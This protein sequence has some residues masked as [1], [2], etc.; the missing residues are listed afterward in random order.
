MTRAYQLPAHTTTDER[1]LLEES[2]DALRR[3]IL[4]D[5]ASPNSI[6]KASSELRHVLLGLA[7]LDKAEP[8]G[9]DVDPIEALKLRV[10]SITTTP[11]P[12]TRRKRASK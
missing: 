5:T 9:P 10:T 8:K 3:V 4:D 1:Q 11:K 12:T 7:E 6:A 2:R